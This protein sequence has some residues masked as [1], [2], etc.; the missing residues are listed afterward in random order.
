MT[1]KLSK[2]E[3]CIL[4]SILEEALKNESCPLRYHVLAEK[5]N[6]MRME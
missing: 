5:L 2:H 1:E 6:K 3:I 4:L